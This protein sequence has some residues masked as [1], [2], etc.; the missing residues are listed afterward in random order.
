[1]TALF[2]SPKPPKPAPTIDPNDVA[3]RRGESR[4]R[5][6]ATGGS[7]ATLL[8]DRIET[9]EAVRDRQRAV[10]MRD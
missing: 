5:R 3:N 2:S 7:A 10:G 8:T 9:R 6:L 4:L 1:M